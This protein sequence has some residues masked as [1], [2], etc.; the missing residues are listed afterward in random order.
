MILDLPKPSNT[1]SNSPSSGKLVR[2]S[3]GHSF[4]G[5][6]LIFIKLLQPRCSV[7]EQEKAETS[8]PPRCSNT[9]EERTTPAAR[10]QFLL[11]FWTSQ[12]LP[13]VVH[14]RPYSPATPASSPK[15][16]TKA[17]KAKRLETTRGCD[18][19]ILRDGSAVRKRS[20]PWVLPSD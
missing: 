16:K 10:R 12:V 2:K 3:S 6:P 18:P 19:S 7:G 8:K 20:P 14:C 15:R 17:S 9:S 5:K 13:V 1:C 11:A 4:L